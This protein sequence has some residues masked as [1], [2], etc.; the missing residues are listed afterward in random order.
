MKRSKLKQL[1]REE[2]SFASSDPGCY[3]ADDIYYIKQNLPKIIEYFNSL[4]ISTPEYNDRKNRLIKIYK[5]I[6]KKSNQ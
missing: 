5:I 4:S 2:L 3:S 6:S 1:I